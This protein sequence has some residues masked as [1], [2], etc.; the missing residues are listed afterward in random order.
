MQAR[1]L[2]NEGRRCDT[3]CADGFYALDRQLILDTEK[4]TEVRR[5][6]DRLDKDLSEKKLSAAGKP[7]L[8]HRLGNR[9]L[10][11]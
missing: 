1:V 2:R 3:A 7:R 9:S 11:N 8:S 10:A 4:Q 6:V 5:L